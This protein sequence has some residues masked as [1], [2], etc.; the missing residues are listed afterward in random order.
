MYYPDPGRYVAMFTYG[1][2]YLWKEGMT[3]YLYCI[4]A[5]RLGPAFSQINLYSHTEASMQ[6]K[7]KKSKDMNRSSVSIVQEKHVACMSVIS[8][9]GIDMM[10]SVSSIGY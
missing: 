9:G 8:F 4:G 7:T 3:M 1:R 6:Y 5:V 10:T 2:K